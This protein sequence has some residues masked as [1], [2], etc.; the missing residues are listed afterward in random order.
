VKRISI[1]VVAYPTLWLELSFIVGTDVLVNGYSVFKDQE[2][3][4]P[5]K[6]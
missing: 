2:R 3:I 4:C 5:L 1:K 6:W